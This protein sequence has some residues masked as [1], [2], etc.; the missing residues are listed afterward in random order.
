MVCHR[1]VV[2]RLFVFARSPVKDSH[3]IPLREDYLR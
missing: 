3:N 2:E 1:P